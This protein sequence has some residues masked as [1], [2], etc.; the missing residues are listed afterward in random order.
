MAEQLSA[1]AD[2]FDSLLS[3]QPEEETEQPDNSVEESVEQP[4]EPTDEPVEAAEEA[5]DNSAD[6]PDG[7]TAG[8]SSY[9][10]AGHES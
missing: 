10:S 6:E 4:E 8:K 5:S 7:P 9:A 2:Q 1:I 3:I